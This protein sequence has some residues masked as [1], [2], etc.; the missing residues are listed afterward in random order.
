MSAAD[1]ARRVV[2]ATEQAAGG[3]AAD[4][5]DDWARHLSDARAYELAHD[6]RVGRTIGRPLSPTVSVDLMAGYSLDGDAAAQAPAPA[7]YTLDGDAAAEAPA[8]YT[9]DRE[10]GAPREATADPEQ[11]VRLVDAAGFALTGELGQGGM[12]VVH[13]ATQ[14]G[15]G[16]EVAVKTL[17]PE[18]AHTAAAARFAAEARITGRL[19]HPGVVPVHA[20]GV[21]PAGR[22]ALVM[23]R[24]RGVAWT[25]LLAQRPPDGDAHAAR[26]A[27]RRHLGILQRVAETVAFAHERGVIHRDLKPDNILIGQFEEVLVTDWGIA[28]E[29]DARRAPP[30]GAPW[31]LI[32]TPSY[33]APEM[34]APD[35]RRQG[36]WTDVFLLGGLLYEVLTGGP[37]HP[38]ATVMEAV[39]HAGRGHVTPPAHRAPDRLVPAE[40]SDI[41]LRALDAD[42]TRRFPSATAFAAALD[43]FLS[44]QEAAAIAAEALDHLARVEA[45][46]AAAARPPAALYTAFAQVTAQL[47]QSLTLWPQGRRARE[48]LHRARA[49]WA[50]LALTQRDVNA[51]EAQVAEL[52]PDLPRTVML[53]RDIAA[54]RARQR[55]DRRLR[56]AVLVGIAV[57]ALVALVGGWTTLRQAARADRAEA[58]AARRDAALAKVEGA[59]WKEPADRIALYEA[60]IAL[61][62][63]WREAY[64]E[65]NAAW[66]ERALDEADD[67]PAACAA[68]LAAA[69]EVLDRVLAREPG[70]DVA[71]YY[72]GYT[73]QMMG[74]GPGALPDLEAAARAAPSGHDGLA[75]A[76]VIALSRGDVAEAK[77]LATAAIAA[78]GDEDDYAR[79]ALARY[80]E[81]DLD[82]ALADLA[83]AEGF[84]PAEEDYDSF[85]ALFH[86]ARGDRRAASERLVAGVAAH[87]RTPHILPLLAY[88]AATRGDTDEARALEAAARAELKAYA[89]CFLDFALVTQIVGTAPGE[90]GV[91]GRAA[92]MREDLSGLSPAQP[93][94][95]VALRAQA[96]AALDGGDATAALAL[97]ERVLADE[98]ADG[99][100]RLLRARA[101]IALGH[102]RAAA[103]DLAL[104]P[105]LAPTRAAEAA[106]FAAALA[107]PPSGVV[108]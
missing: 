26:E 82:G 57:A 41:A 58:A 19:E 2:G 65:L 5:A 27:L 75:A 64:A 63:S 28:L 25:Q 105:R 87:T 77:R 61:D 79:R 24:I 37:P 47:G 97:T 20:Y 3:G 7:A 107:D 99:L 34:L 29:L 70:Y 36:P 35:E 66:L 44:N 6:T 103:R 46:V 50:E 78:Q 48:G 71:L 68:S 42:P 67:D 43:E 59:A 12:G 18:L 15:L 72:R 21:D 98:P 101:L 60:A 74:D 52:P 92:L 83:A 16:R 88:L 1:A 102:P 32:G 9:L 106:A 86:L 91:L 14:T 30:P 23:K 49:A 84:R 53:R 13:E 31:D 22:P 85:A 76:T 39:R 11:R 54:L 40:L 62:P 95:T 69:R 45:D 55:R 4:S 56:L 89:G 8:P 33:L 94:P 51:A 100:T 73:S 93:P 10:A 81:G 90:R 17:R 96:Q 80:V 38:G 108:P 104:V